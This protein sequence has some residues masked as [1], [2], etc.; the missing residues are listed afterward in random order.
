MKDND[1]KIW[2]WVEFVKPSIR[3]LFGYELHVATQLMITHLTSYRKNP[4]YYHFYSSSFLMFLGKA[5]ECQ[6]RRR[7]INRR[8][9]G[10]CSLYR[11]AFPIL[12]T[13]FL[14]NIFQHKLS[15]HILPAPQS[16]RMM[17]LQSP[18]IASHRIISAQ[19]IKEIHDPQTRSY[20][21]FST[22]VRRSC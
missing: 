18:P 9:H 20:Q 16:F 5:R 22:L 2:F 21:S 7:K 6:R 11:G 13:V 8:Q 4:T 10:Y 19:M 1:E 3:R 12:Y 17:H 15:R 14:M